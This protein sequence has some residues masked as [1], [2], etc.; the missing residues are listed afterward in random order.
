VKRTLS[1]RRN[2][3]GTVTL[4]AAL[5][6]GRK[7]VEHFDVESKGLLETFESV[8]FAALTAGLHLSDRSLEDLLREARGLQ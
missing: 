1:V 2:R 6:D 8:R 3:D 5:P 7:Y 4:R